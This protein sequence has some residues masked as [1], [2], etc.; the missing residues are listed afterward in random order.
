MAS[1]ALSLRLQE[2]GTREQA[3]IRIT[4]NGRPRAGRLRLSLTTLISGRSWCAQALDPRAVAVCA[5][6][7]RCGTAKFHTWTKCSAVALQHEG[8]RYAVSGA[9]LTCH[10]CPS[11]WFQ[12][13]GGRAAASTLPAFSSMQIDLCKFCVKRWRLAGF[14]LS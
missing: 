5:A 6:Q 3:Q 2:S 1:Q 11:N 14:L 7:R 12:S 9:L 4:H 10:R 13:D 8:E